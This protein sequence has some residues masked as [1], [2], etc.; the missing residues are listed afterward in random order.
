MPSPPP[1]LSSDSVADQLGIDISTLARLRAYADLLVKW[2]KRINLV[3]SR[4]VPDLWRRHMLDSA[5]LYLHLPPG[6]RVL[7]DLGSGAGFP[8]LVLAI[9]GVPEVHLFESDT[10]KGAFLREAARVTD[11]PVTVHTARIE[12]ES[13]FAADVVTAR[14][15]APL[16]RLLAYGERF[17]VENTVFLFLKGQNLQQE[18]TDSQK[19]WNMAVT[20]TKSLSDPS[21]VVVR[22]ERITRRYGHAD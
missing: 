6:A 3:G 13:G 5:Q 4:T 2:Q 18:L 21:G 8:G 14:A 17:L 20:Q 16:S 15:L 11:T 12:S 10:R 22:L 19:N 9:L 7:V 1:L